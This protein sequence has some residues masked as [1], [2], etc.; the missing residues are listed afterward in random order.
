MALS[1]SSVLLL[2]NENPGNVTPGT[3]IAVGSQTGVKF[4]RKTSNIDISDKTTA[5]KKFM[6]GEREETITLDHMYVPGDAGLAALKA[7]FAAGSLIYVERQESGSV[8]EYANAVITQISEDAKK[9][10]A[11]T[12]AVSL[13]VSGGWTPGGAP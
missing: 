3:Y 8:V 13:T 12:V 2:V 11:S 6:P 1:G 5:E 9:A 4:D 7:A 10:A